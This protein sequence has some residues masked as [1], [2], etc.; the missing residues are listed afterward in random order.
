[1]CNRTLQ[2]YATLYENSRMLHEKGG[3][4]PAIDKKSFAACMDFVR[5]NPLCYDKDIHA[6]IDSE[7]VEL[8]FRLQ[9]G[10]PTFVF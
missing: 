8:G 4:S 7:V 6:Q 3:R 1:M 9:C 2:R 10:W 5:A